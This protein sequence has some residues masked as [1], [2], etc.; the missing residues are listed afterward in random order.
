MSGDALSE[1]EG[2][3]LEY[4]WIAQSVRGESLQIASQRSACSLSDAMYL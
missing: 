2:D 3:G 1:S 4:A